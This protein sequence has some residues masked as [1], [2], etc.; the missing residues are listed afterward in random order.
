M[1]LRHHV[2]PRMGPA[3]RRCRACRRSVVAV[4]VCVVCGVGAP[5]AFARK[6]HKP[7]PPPPPPPTTSSATG[8]VALWHMDETSGTVMSDSVGGHTGTLHSVQLGQPGF[9]GTAF[10]FSGGYVSVPSAG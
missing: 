8:T 4:L 1:V 9:L 5:N 10:G 7:Q 6:V 2:S 3:V